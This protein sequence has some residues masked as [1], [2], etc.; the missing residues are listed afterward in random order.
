[1]DAFGIYG[2]AMQGDL[3]KISPKSETIFT[4]ILL[5]KQA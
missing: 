4:H 5:K 1:M 2:Y 3:E